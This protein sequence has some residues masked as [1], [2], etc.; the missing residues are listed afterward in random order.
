MRYIMRNKKFGLKVTA[1]SEA[2]RDK[3]L[4]AAK[5]ENGSP[6]WEVF[7]ELPD[8]TVAKHTELSREELEAL[9]ASKDEQIARMTKAEAD[10]EI[11]DNPSQE[12]P[13]KRGRKP[14]VVK[15]EESAEES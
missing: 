5:R 12:I 14:K 8:E 13:K 4:G 2:C 11:L 15:D 9:L 1:P 3:I 6:V 7:S 10:K